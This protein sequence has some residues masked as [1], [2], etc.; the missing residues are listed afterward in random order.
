MSRSYRK[1]GPYP[2]E[3]KCESIS[4]LRFRSPKKINGSCLCV[5]LSA[6]EIS[7]Y[8]GNGGVFCK[9]YQFEKFKK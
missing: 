3:S 4:N 7:I 8:S 2:G 1:S 9:R 6:G 5:G